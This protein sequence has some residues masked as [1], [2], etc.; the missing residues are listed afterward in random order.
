MALLRTASGDGPEVWCRCDGGPHGFLSI[1]AHAHADALSVEVRHDGVEVLV[2]PG[3]YCYHGEPE[4][5]GYFRSTLAH[6]TVSVDGVDQSVDGGPFLW[7]THAATTVDR[8][9]LDGDEPTW[10]AHHDGYERLPGGVRHERSVTLARSRREVR[11]ADVVTG[12]GAHE[13][14]L[15]FHLGPAVEVRLTGSTAE[16]AWPGRDGTPQSAALEL[17]SSLSWSAHRGE[18]RPVLGWYSP[19]FGVKEPTTTLVGTGPLV[20][21]LELASLLRFAPASQEAAGADRADA[22]MLAGEPA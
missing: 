17:P 9:V 1:A 18:V 22:T 19:G 13:V 12:D 16:L 11:I 3:T 15:A 14:S 5:R 8:V 21:R 4:W 10:S 2:D 20:G 7:R 6:N